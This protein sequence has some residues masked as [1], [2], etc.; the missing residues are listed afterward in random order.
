MIPADTILITLMNENG[1]QMV[2]GESIFH[3]T[4]VV[5]WSMGRA[6]FMMQCFSLL[7]RESIFHY[8]MVLPTQSGEH[9]S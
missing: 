9:F 5:K 8:T 1:G 2:N 4:M 6:F 3:D 7:S